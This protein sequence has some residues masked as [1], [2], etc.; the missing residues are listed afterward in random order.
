MRF[1]GFRSSLWFSNGLI[2]TII[3]LSWVNKFI[4]LQISKNNL[5]AWKICFS[6]PFVCHCPEEAL[7]I[8]EK[9]LDVMGHYAYDFIEM[10]SS[11]SKSLPDTKI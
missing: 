9:S 4:S 11:V 7:E 5:G 6:L 8:M 10:L 2:C 3:G 1:L